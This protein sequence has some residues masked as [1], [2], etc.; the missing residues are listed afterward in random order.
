[1]RAKDAVQKEEQC[2]TRFA[3]S[4][5]GW[6][7]TSHERGVDDYCFLHGAL[8]LIVVDALVITLAVDAVGPRRTS[9]PNLFPKCSPQVHCG[10][11]P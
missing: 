3:T 9:I 4:S 7:G 1:M 5:R 10:A 6:L 11:A 2:V 8:L